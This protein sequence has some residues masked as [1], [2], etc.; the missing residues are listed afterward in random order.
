MLF[1]RHQIKNEMER[2]MWHI[3]RR[4]ENFG[5]ETLGQKTAWKTQA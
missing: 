2:G 5:G 4:G 1:T 3:W